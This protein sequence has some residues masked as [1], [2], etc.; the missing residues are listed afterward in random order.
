M[1]S[2][3]TLSTAA[4]NGQKEGPCLDQKAPGLND[5]E[6]AICAS[7]DLGIQ[8]IE[9]PLVNTT[10]ENFK[11]LRSGN[12]FVGPFVAPTTL[13]HSARYRANIAAAWMNGGESESA[14]GEAAAAARENALT[15]YRDE[16]KDTIFC[17][18]R[19]LQVDMDHE[20]RREASEWPWVQT[21][22][23]F[24]L[25][26]QCGEGVFAIRDRITDRLNPR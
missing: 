23:Q 12:Q 15:L 18:F 19:M 1:E 13:L 22:L 16:M 14:A 9:P 11:L 6:L 24:C 5:Y 7:I 2:I 17:L 21:L 26:P 3:A 20:L 8:N 25:F 4:E 10:I